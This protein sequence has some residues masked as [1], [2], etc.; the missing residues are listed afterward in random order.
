MDLRKPFFNLLIKLAERDKDIVLITGD[1][2]FSFIE[3][4]AKRFPKQ[5]INAGCI[6]QSM[7]GIAAGLAS[8]GK[9]PYVYSGSVFLLMRPYEQV[10]DDI[11]Y[12]ESNVK[13]IGTKHS[14]F[15]GFTHNLE[16]EENIADLLKNL[17]NLVSYYPKTEVE[18]NKIM[19]KKDKKPTFIQL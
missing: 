18:L 4:Y 15:L 13:L 5:Y 14:G 8:T 17:P 2:G 7:I 1:L 12:N 10:R 11:C 6:E 9:K 3:E 16:K 19:R